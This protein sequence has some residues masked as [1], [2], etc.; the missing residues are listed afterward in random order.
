MSDAIVHKIF[1]YPHKDGCCEEREVCRVAPGTGL[2]GD[3]RRSTRRSVTL[4][5]SEIWDQTMAGLG[6]DLS[7]QARRANL[8]V[9][10]VDLPA[11]VGK[12]LRIGA[13]LF[14][15]WGETEPC[16]KMDDK[17]PGLLAAL[18]PEMRGG[19][20]AEVLEAG[21][22]EIGAPIEVEESA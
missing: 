22:L 16:Q 11:T 6:I 5:S 7:P 12:C 14:R 21:L 18:T 13:A 2:D 3:R 9:G 8:L 4:L 20:C 10:G 1:I 15:I 17:Y 19:V